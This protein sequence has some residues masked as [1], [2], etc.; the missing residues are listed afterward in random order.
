MF[1][2]LEFVPED[3]VED[4]RAMLSVFPKIWNS[5][6]N[7]KYLSSTLIPF[8]V[9]L[10]QGWLENHKQQGGRYFCALDERG[11]ILAIM[12]VKASPLDG[13]EIYGLGVLPGSKR[14]GVGRGLV[15]HAVG[16]AGDLGFKDV[17]MMVFADNAAMLCLVLN[18]GFIPVSIERHRRADGVDA[19]QLRKI[20]PGAGS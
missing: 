17:K 3:R 14:S 2:V 4:R 10:I 11:D 9:E 20:L 18:L 7:L 13:F 1:K 6:E 5:P 19:V 12:V 16:L 8:E 15:E